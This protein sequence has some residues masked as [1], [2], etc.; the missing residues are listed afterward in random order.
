[1]DLQ[2]LRSSAKLGN[3][4]QVPIASGG[5]SELEVPADDEGSSI[6]QDEFEEC[7]AK[8]KER[9]KSQP[10]TK[11]ASFRGLEQ[12]L[13]LTETILLRPFI[14]KVYEFFSSE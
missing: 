4:Q 3:Q 12:A 1:M 13:S 6:Y 2:R 14:G 10:M 8:P 11:N 7:F 9:A 5:D